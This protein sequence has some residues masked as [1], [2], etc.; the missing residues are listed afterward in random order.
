MIALED[1]AGTKYRKLVI[2]DG[3][4]I[5]AILLGYQAEVAPVR[6]AIS[7][8]TDVSTHLDRAARGTVGGAG[9]GIGR[10]GRASSLA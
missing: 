1:D 4:I 5:G 8:R 9:G 10:S 6:A 2:S 3:R 7:A